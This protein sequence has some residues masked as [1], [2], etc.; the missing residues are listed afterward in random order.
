MSYQYAFLAWWFQ[1]N[2]NLLTQNEE[3]NL[4][5]NFGGDSKYLKPSMYQFIAGFHTMFYGILIKHVVGR[6]GS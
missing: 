1:G 4:P 6:V 3:S 5:P 2:W